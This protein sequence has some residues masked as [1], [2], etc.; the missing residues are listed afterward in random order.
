MT[1]PLI[2]TVGELLW[3]LLP[4][5]PRLGG[6]PS[7][8]AVMAARLGNH[9]ALLSRVGRDRLGP[10]ALEFLA[11][12]PLDR[13]LIQ[14]SADHPT[15]SVSVSFGEN[16]QPAYD[17]RQKV[18]WDFIE[19]SCEAVDLAPSVA[20]V[21]FGSLAQRAATTREALRGFLALT[22]PGC[23][24]L[25]DANLR[26]PYFTPKVIRWSLHHASIIK[27]SLEELPQLAS[28]AELDFPEDDDASVAEVAARV[29]LASYP[30]A[31]LIAITMGDEGSLLATREETH[32][33]HGFAI[34][35]VDTVGAGD[36]FTAGLLHARLRGASLSVSS[37]VANLCGSYVA[38]Q[39]GAMPELS[40]EFLAQ[41]ASLLPQE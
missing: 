4:A 22:P 21:C 33:H 17:I 20:A 29:M 32:R 35:V 30:E 7:N 3:D 15:G 12:T 38:S 37:E 24:R 8:L 23:I 40:V 5:G 9:A 2:V 13:S 1:P 26:A 6:A 16:G 27:V 36:A 14:Q 34:D 39:P 19:L 41:V 31:K 10:Q 25:F 28:L 11:T 18:A